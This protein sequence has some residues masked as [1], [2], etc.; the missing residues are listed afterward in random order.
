MKQLKKQKKCI[1]Q[2]KI[3]KIKNKQKQKKKKNTT[4]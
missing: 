4:H 3:E 2:T 1:A